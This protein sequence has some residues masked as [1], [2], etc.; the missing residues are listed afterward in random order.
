MGWGKRGANWQLRSVLL[1]ACKRSTRG[2][3]GR[4]ARHVHFVVSPCSI[5][6]HSFSR[7]L[8]SDRAFRSVLPLSECAVTVYE[9]STNLIPRYQKNCKTFLNARIHRYIPFPQTMLND[10]RPNYERHSVFAMRKE[11]P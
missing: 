11:T 10:L 3:S 7:R 1:W 6:S 2:K 5:H 4:V 9:C 8:V